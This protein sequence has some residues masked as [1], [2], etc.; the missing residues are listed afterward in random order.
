MSVVLT[1]TG[2]E[3]RLLVSLAAW[4]WPGTGPDDG[5]VVHIVITHSPPSPAISRPR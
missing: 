1:P 2:P 3:L 4:T 5:E